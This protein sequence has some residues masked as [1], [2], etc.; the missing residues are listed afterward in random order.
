MDESMDDFWTTANLRLLQKDTTG[1]TIN[2]TYR[3][4]YKNFI[5]WLQ[6]NRNSSEIVI[7]NEEAPNGIIFVT[8]HNVEKYFQHV[9]VHKQTNKNGCMRIFQA[10]DSVLHR[11]ESN[12]TQNLQKSNFIKQKCEKQHQNYIATCATKNLVVDPHKGLKSKMT[13]EE[14]VNIISTIYNHRKDSLDLAFSFLVGINAGTRGCSSRQFTLSDL[15][16]DC[17]SG[18]ESLPPRNKTLI[19]ILRK[20]AF[21]KENFATDR[22]VGVQR[23]K[24]FKLCAVFATAS[25]VI[26]K[27]RSI[28]PSLNFFWYKNQGVRPNWWDI[29]LNVYENLEDESHAMRDVLKKAGVNMCGKITHHR[30]QAVQEAGSKDLTGEQIS[31]MTKHITDKL[32]VAYLPEVNQVT[33]KVMSGFEK[34]SSD[35]FCSKNFF[36]TLNFFIF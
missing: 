26:M 17:A 28:G 1:T 10:L 23:H 13:A 29:P 34:V 32:H 27:L 24:N 6:S 12:L 2:S 14:K 16:L 20:G 4:I 9:V 33:M 22:Q 21:C 7:L 36:L 25:L 3:N 30:L 18:P 35:F 19:F 11:I 31:T 5:C 8:Q 15:N